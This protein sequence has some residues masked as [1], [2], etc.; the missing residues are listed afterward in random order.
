[1]TDGPAGAPG[2]LRLA[3][4]TARSVLLSVLLGSH[5]PELPVRALVG[6]A[7]LF[8]ISHGSARVAL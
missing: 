7:E 8:G 1:M 5:P 3:P 2:A 4:L 6:A